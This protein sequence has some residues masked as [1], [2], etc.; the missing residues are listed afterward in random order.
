MAGP[1]WFGAGAFDQPTLDLAA[2]I[3]ADREDMLQTAYDPPW[4]RNTRE[5][6]SVRQV[7]GTE[8]TASHGEDQPRG[9][10]C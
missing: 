1:D 4:P 7:R 5:A 6:S 3:V 8:Y 9:V 2:K 10:G